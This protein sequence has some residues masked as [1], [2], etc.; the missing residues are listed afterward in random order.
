MSTHQDDEFGDGTPGAADAA[1]ALAV[2]R[3][4]DALQDAA[5]GIRPSPWPGGAVLERARRRRRTGRLTIAL[6]AAA[7][8]AAAGG[9]IVAAQNRAGD[10]TPAGQPAGPPAAPTPTPTRPETRQA[11]HTAIPDSRQAASPPADWPAVKVVRPGEV[12][13]LGKGTRLRLDA[14]RR[15]LD[16]S[17]TWDCKNTADGNQA[18]DS[19]SLQSQGDAN[20][21]LYTPLYIGRGTPARMSVTVRG[22]LYPLQVVTLPGRPGYATGYGRAPSALAGRAGSPVAFGDVQVTVYDAQGAVL[23]SLP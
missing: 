10:A 18:A 6:S 9:G 23:A 13:V 8:V 11:E 12:V 17:G 14:H 7:V 5:S 3:L 19:V 1:Q 20:G 2:E 21:T 4:R 16:T 15:C 22:H